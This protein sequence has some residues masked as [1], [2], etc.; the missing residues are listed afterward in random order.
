MY[1]IGIIYFA[2]TYTVVHTH[3]CQTP[4]GVTFPN[5]FF[6]FG[7]GDSEDE[8][9]SKYHQN[10]DEIGFLFRCDPLFLPLLGDRPIMG[11]GGS[12]Q[13]WG[14]GHSLKEI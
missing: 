7:G 10:P 6:F 9:C 1:A 13:H 2:H 8:K 3:G 4:I 11:D 14:V 5:R 12:A